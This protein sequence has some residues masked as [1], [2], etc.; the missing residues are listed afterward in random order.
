MIKTLIR[1]IHIIYK[2]EDYWCGNH[3]N[4]VVT[5]TNSLSSH[6][7]QISTINMLRNCEMRCDLK[8]IGVY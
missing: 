2:F 5:I 8:T 4:K 7:I 6:V 3:I 1:Y